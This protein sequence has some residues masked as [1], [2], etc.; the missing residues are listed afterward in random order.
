[1]DL[2]DPNDRQHTQDESDMITYAER[3]CFTAVHVQLLRYVESC[4]ARIGASWGNEL[5]C[6]ELARAVQRVS[7]HKPYALIVEDGKCGPIEHSWLCFSDG[8]ILD[9]YVPGR[10]PAVQLIDPIVGAA[11]RSGAPRADI[12]PAIIDQLVL[13]MSRDVTSVP[14]PPARSLARD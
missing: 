3:V 2:S 11:Y 9:P 4:V 5:R 14:V 10:M 13:E 8:M 12:Q 7:A 6:H 1:M